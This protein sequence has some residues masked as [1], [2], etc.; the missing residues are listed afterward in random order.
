MFWLFGNTNLM[1]PS[2]FSGPGR[3]RMRI[4]P[5]STALRLASFSVGTAVVPDTNS[6]PCRVK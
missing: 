2:A 6:K 3:W 4:L 1:S 5:A